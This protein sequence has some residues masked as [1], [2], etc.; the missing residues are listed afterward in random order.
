M[1]LGTLRELRRETN[2]YQNW[3][4]Y[5]KD[6][7]IV[8]YIIKNN[9]KNMPKNVG[10]PILLS[11]IFRSSIEKLCSVCNLLYLDHL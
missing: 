1:S 8:N 9:N 11:P 4:L 5:Y 3:F 10:F 6:K 2:R 7:Q